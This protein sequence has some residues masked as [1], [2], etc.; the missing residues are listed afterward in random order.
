V[1]V[2]VEWK[3]KKVKAVE[4]ASQKNASEFEYY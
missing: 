4:D 1:H 3:M 2:M